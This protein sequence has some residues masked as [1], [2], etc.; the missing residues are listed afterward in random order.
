MFHI[1][2]SKKVTTFIFLLELKLLNLPGD[3]V[4]L[5]SLSSTVWLVSLLDLFSG[6][7]K[8]LKQNI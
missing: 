8:K 4:V 5:L 7:L 2:K 3:P 6:Y 1:Q